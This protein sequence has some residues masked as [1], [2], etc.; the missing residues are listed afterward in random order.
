MVVLG[1][2][3]NDDGTMSDTMKIRLD[4]ALKLYKEMSFKYIV[5]SGGVANIKA[6]ISEASCMFNYLVNNGI[7]ES[8]LIKEDKSTSTY[9]NALFTMEKI[10]NYDFNN[11]VI[12]S[13]IEHF[14]NYKTLKYFN[15]AIN[16]NKI[17]K[18][19]NINIMIY[20]NS[21]NC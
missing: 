11:L 15:D 8:I 2:W 14:I 16:N 10:E 9:E 19:K 4:L 7:R 3:M 21:Y 12:V 17:L 13:T 6:G 18:D 20:T 1:N 5:L